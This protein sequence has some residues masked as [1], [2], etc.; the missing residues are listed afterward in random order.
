MCKC[1]SGPRSGLRLKEINVLHQCTQLAYTSRAPSAPHRLSH[2][3]SVTLKPRCH[4]HDHKRFRPSLPILAHARDNKTR[5]SCNPHD[6]PLWAW[7]H[8]SRGQGCGGSNG[9]PC[10]T[11]VLRARVPGRAKVRLVRTN[12]LRLC[13]GSAYMCVL[14]ERR[15]S[16]ACARPQ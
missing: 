15:S 7:P 13:E 16:I 3:S 8:C 14:G 12:L 1:H 10:S 9:T 4:T 11:R 6:L 2:E 5:C